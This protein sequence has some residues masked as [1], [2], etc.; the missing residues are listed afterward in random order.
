MLMEK[1][2]E[3]RAVLLHDKSG[4]WKHRT[5]QCNSGDSLGTFDKYYRFSMKHKKERVRELERETP[6]TM[7]L[8]YTLY[9]LVEWN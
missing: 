3:L 1:A 4:L 7:Q 6:E 8:E 5:I 9:P 2:R